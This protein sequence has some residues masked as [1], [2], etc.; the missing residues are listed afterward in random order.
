MLSNQ[1]SIFSRPRYT[2]TNLVAWWDAAAASTVAR[3]TNNYVSQ[4]T[5]RTSNAR[6]LVQATQ[7]NKPVYQSTG[8]GGLGA[9]AFTGSSQFMTFNDQSMAFIAGTSFTIFIVATKTALSANSYVIGGTSTNTRSNFYTGYLSANTYRFGFGNDDSAAIVTN[10]TAGQA[11]V[12]T[13]IYNTADNSKRIRRNGVD[14]GVGAASGSLSGM[15]GQALGR[16]LTSYGQFSV[17]EMLFYS[18]AKTASTYNV[19]EQSLIAKW[20]VPTP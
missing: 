3:D 11:E 4:W 8:I 10:A 20:A 7:G 16:Y 2:R 15:T 19:I 13:L 14:V 6:T 9:I 17:G 5:D 18:D 1:R 12:Y